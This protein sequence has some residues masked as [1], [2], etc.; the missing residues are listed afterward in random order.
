[1]VSA[2]ADRAVLAALP[3]S[4]RVMV[5]DVMRQHAGLTAVEALKALRDAGM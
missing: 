4:E 1:V 5:K 2:D 3:D